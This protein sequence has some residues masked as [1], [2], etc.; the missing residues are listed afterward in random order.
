MSMMMSLAAGAGWKSFT[1]GTKKLAESGSDAQQ[2]FS[3][4]NMP[5]FLAGAGAKDL[6][7]SME[8]IGPL[9]KMMQP[10]APPQQ[11]Q[12]PE[13]AAAAMQMLSAQ[14]GSG[15]KGIQAPPP[16]VPGGGMPPRPGMGMPM[17]PGMPGGMPPGPQGMY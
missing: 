6:G 2:L 4:P 5:L 14:L 12:K 7:N 8:L 3:L 1:E 16:G 10:P 9:M 17:R 15:L 11:E 13:E